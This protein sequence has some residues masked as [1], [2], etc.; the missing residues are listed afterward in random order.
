MGYAGDGLVGD[1]SVMSC[2]VCSQGERRVS[3]TKAGWGY[4][5]RVHST[6]GVV[7][8]VLRGRVV[9]YDLHV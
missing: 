7:G 2:D 5:R 3:T 1:C 4:N 6:D 9:N 8:V